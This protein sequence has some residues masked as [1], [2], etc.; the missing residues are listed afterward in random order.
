MQGLVMDVH[1]AA[2]G[3]GVNDADAGADR[4]GVNT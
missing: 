3:I 4:A 2:D 1:A